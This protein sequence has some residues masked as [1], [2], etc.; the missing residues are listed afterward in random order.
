MRAGAASESIAPPPGLPMLGFVRAQQGATT[1]G[2]PLEATAL[3]LEEGETRIAL[4][5][6][7]T[8]GL[9]T[10]DCDRLRA[11][12]AAETGAEPAAILLNWNH[13]HRA[14]PASRAFLLRTGLLASDGDDRI[15]AYAALVADAVVTAARR[16]AERLEPAA[17]A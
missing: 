6:V 4:C 9:P 7:D 5:G 3:V 17:V 12:I 14:P 13:T 8:L 1:H 16:A 10:D 2:L 11:R 15:D